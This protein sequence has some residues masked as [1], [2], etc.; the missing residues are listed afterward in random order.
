VNKNNK[1]VPKN[2]S[3]IVIPIGK[4]SLIT[5][6]EKIDE[7]L[8]IAGHIFQK[9]NE[10]KIMNHTL[11]SEAVTVTVDD[12]DEVTEILVKL[13]QAEL[14]ALPSSKYGRDSYGRTLN[15]DGTP[16]KARND[17]GWQSI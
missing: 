4:A 13:S 17:R 8:E 11:T 12:N 1:L 7:A 3:E 9:Q 10:G 16:R 2:L 6:Q 14:D 15:K 5:T